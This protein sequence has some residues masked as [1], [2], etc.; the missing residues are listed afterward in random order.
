MNYAPNLESI[1]SQER[2]KQRLNYPDD[3]MTLKTVSIHDSVCLQAAENCIDDQY[4]NAIY[5][6]HGMQSNQDGVFGFS[7]VP[8]SSQHFIRSL[9][10][11]G[12][13]DNAMISL[14]ISKDTNVHKSHLQIG[15]YNPTFVEGGESA[16]S[17]VE[18]P[19]LS[20]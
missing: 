1:V 19:S 9:H 17:W 13:I 14:F 2:P 20:G 6:Q 4:F 8:A 16:L 18:S 15:S 3:Q 5:S 11:E 7:N 10:N 12:I